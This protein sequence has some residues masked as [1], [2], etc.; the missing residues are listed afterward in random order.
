MSYV[1]LKQEEVDPFNRLLNAASAYCGFVF[2]KRSKKEISAK[3]KHLHLC[4]LEPAL[5]QIAPLCIQ[6]MRGHLYNKEQSDFL[7]R[8]DEN[9]LRYT[10]VYAFATAAADQVRVLELI[11]VGRLSTEFRQETHEEAFH[12]KFV[13]HKSIA[14]R[15]LVRCL[16]LSRPDRFPEDCECMASQKPSDREYYESYILAMQCELVQDVT[17]ICKMF[18][19]LVSHTSNDYWEFSLYPAIVNPTIEDIRGCFGL[20]CSPEFVRA[21][22]DRLAGQAL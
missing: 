16:F 10:S 20:N 5:I 6:Q 1:L 14:F 18:P 15:D 8:R 22:Q 19:A 12:R 4:A 7:R 3:L 9:I 2:Q 17:K 21:V 13:L 11:A